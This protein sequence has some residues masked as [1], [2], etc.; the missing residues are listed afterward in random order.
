MNTLKDKRVDCLYFIGDCTLKEA[1]DFRRVAISLDKMKKHQHIV[2]I[3]S[4]SIENGI[5][6]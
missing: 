1:A 4:I 2:D 3:I 5:L 6:H